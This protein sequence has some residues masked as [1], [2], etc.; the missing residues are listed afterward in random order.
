MN[1]CLLTSFSKAFL[2]LEYCYPSCLVGSEQL[3]GSSNHTKKVLDKYPELG[4]F[5]K[6]ENILSPLHFLKKSSTSKQYNFI[7]F[8]YFLLLFKLKKKIKTIQ[9]FFTFL[10]KWCLLYI[11]SITTYYYSKLILSYQIRP[12]FGN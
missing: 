3:L 11:T 10:Y 2:Y 5:G 12:L 4:L 8:Q 7:S 9:N 6:G 1:I